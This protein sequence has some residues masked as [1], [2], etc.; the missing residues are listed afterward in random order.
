MEMLDSMEDVIYDAIWAIRWAALD[1]HLDEVLTRATLH[2][3]LAGTWIG[4]TTSQVRV[5]FA[6]V[7]PRTSR[8]GRLE[9]VS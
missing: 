7:M 5:A 4:Q 3:Y 6:E 8:Q 1:V 2:V 9:L